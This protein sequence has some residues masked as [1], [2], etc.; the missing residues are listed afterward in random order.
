MFSEIAPQGYFFALRAQGV[1]SMC[2]RLTM[3]A[4]VGTLLNLS[5]FLCHCEA[6][7]RG[8]KKRRLFG[9]RRSQDTGGIFR[10]RKMECGILCFD[11]VAIRPLSFLEYGFS[12]LLTQA[13]NDR[14]RLRQ[15]LFIKKNP[16]NTGLFFQKPIAKPEKGCYNTSNL[17]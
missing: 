2:H 4:V 9:E 15:S 16:K 13:Q 7:Y 17:A 5:G 8:P 3:T 12:R 11:D 10:L 6:N 14:K 1:T